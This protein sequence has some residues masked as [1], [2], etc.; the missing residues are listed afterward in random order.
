MSWMMEV[1]RKRLSSSQ[2]SPPR[3]SRL[4]AHP[5][6]EPT[7]STFCLLQLFHGVCLGCQGFPDLPCPGAL[8][9]S[10]LFPPLTMSSSLYL[11]LMTILLN[12]KTRTQL[13]F[14]PKK[15]SSLR[16]GLVPRLKKK[17]EALYQNP[18]PCSL[19]MAAM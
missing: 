16:R 14:F 6:S 12:D 2:R 15:C 10:E 3:A 18:S 11:L 7:L 8:Y 19:T 5:H 4:R 9:F 13:N 1:L 17:K